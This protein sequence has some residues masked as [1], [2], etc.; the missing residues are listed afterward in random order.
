M[1]RGDCSDL[2]WDDLITLQ[3]WVDK[4][5]LVKF[6]LNSI[7]YL[8][9]YYIVCALLSYNHHVTPSC[10][11][12]LW[13]PNMWYVMCDICYMTLFYIFFLYSKSR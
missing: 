2:A 13:Y 7:Y 6:L 8:Y 11:I 5:N 4:K 12:T 1:E 9:N 3:V 10:N